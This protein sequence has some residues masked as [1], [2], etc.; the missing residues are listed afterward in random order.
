MLLLVL[1]FLV[2]QL[3]VKHETKAWQMTVIAVSEKQPQNNSSPSCL[4][5]SSALFCRPFRSDLDDRSGVEN[6][7]RMELTSIFAFNL[8]LRMT[9]SLLTNG[10]TSPR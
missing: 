4:V 6:R 2:R 5:V 9:S 1:S 7:R 10:G 3:H 8:Q